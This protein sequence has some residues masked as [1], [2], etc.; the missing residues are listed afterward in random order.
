MRTL[1]EV[2]GRCRIDE[3]TKCWLWAGAV[4]RGQPKIYAPDWTNRDGALTTQTGQRAVWHMLN[5]HAIPK[6]WRVYSTCRTPCCLNPAHLK[7]GSHAEWGRDSAALGDLKGNIRVQIRNRRT[8]RARSELTPETYTEVLLS[9]EKGA[10]IARRLA[11]SESTVSKAR[12]GALVCFQPIG[13]FL[14]GLT[15]SLGKSP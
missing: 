8:G 13:G 2:R 15:T 7:I 3:L 12:T 5:H 9:N 4:D 11:I 10:E 1:E 14:S 6:R